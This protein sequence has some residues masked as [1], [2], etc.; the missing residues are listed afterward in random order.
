MVLDRRKLI[1]VMS[2][3]GQPGLPG[4]ACT[5]CIPGQRGDRGFPG[6]PGLSGQ[7]GEP[8]SEERMRGGTG[9]DRTLHLGFSS[10][11]RTTRRTVS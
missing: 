10:C 1:L 6:T 7:K 4:Q 3:L 5:A 8:V 2:M 9:H 11:T